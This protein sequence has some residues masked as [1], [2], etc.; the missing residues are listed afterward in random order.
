MLFVIYNFNHF[1]SK[2]SIDLG[3]MLLNL[4]KINDQI[5]I[6]NFIVIDMIDNF[7]N[8]EYETWFKT[9]SDPSNAIWIGEGINNQFSIK[10]S[11]SSDRSLQTPITNDFGY[12]VVNG[13]H[14]LIKV[15][16][17]DDNN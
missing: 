7:K 17:F 14:A 11:R 8:I 5:N 3:E 13:K 16:E 12:I 10:L 4:Y 9:I 6:I 15:L 1:K 2:V